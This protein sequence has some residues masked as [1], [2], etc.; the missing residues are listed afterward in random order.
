[1]A[2]VLKEIPLK[3]KQTVCYSCGHTIAYVLNDVKEYHGTD[4]SGG[5][6]GREWI[7]CPNCNKDI[8]LRSW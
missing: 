6:D 1:M 3:E 4:Y 8:I 2:R 5:P 7:V